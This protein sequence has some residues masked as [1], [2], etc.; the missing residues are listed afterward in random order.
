MPTPF[1]FLVVLL[2][3]H[4]INNE[5]TIY[6]LYHLLCGKKSS[7][8]I[9]DAHL[10]Q[11]TRFYKTYSALTRQ[12]FEAIIMEL[13][14]LNLIVQTNEQHYVLT[15]SGRAFMKKESKNYPFLSY[16]NG[17]NYQYSEVFWQR[18]SLVVQVTSHLV[19]EDRNYIPIQRN[20]QLLS[21]LK[22]FFLNNRLNRK[23]FSRKLYE[24]L[25]L[26]LDECAD[27]SPSV[28]IIRLTGYETIG[29]TEKQAFDYLDMEQTLYQYQFQALI[30]YILEK[31]QNDPKRFVL[32]FSL[33]MDVQTSLPITESSKKTLDLLDKGFSIEK[34]AQIRKLKVSTI[35]DHIVELALQVKSFQI[36]PF[37]DKQKMKLI[38]KA[39]EE[40]ASKQLRYIREL[41]PEA[42]Y[43][44]IRLVMSKFGDNNE[45]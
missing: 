31:V 18:L 10:F 9:Q 44:Q 14:R 5:R 43:F 37:V 34:I 4:K 11:I 30:H 27:I 38:L 25:I 12:Q 2:C 36:D 40:A 19:N 15:D 21:W 24:E 32:L 1:L 22:S 7:Q 39:N 6:S 16:L 28:L 20:R 45:S 42:T 29:L 41:V 35:Q 17:W 13:E 33:I 3:L 23:E 8:T 26:V